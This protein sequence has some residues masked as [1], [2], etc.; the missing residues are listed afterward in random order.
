MFI[1]YGASKFFYNNPLDLFNIDNFTFQLSVYNQVSK[2]LFKHQDEENLI[3]VKDINE[4][5]E[6]YYI[7]E[8]FYIGF[9]DE[10]KVNM[11]ILRI[12]LKD[13]I[14][15]VKSL[16]I[17][18]ISLVLKLMVF[19]I[20]IRR[21]VFSFVFDFISS[22]IVDKNLLSMVFIQSRIYSYLGF[23]SMGDSY[24]ISLG[25][26]QDCSQHN[27][28]KEFNGFY[29]LYF[30]NDNLLTYGFYLVLSKK[31]QHF[32]LYGFYDQLAIIFFRFS[33]N[34]SGQYAR[35][36]F[37]FNFLDLFLKTDDFKITLFVLLTTKKK[38]KI[39]IVILLFY[40][41]INIGVIKRGGRFIPFFSVGIS[42]SIDFVEITSVFEESKNKLITL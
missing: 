27:F 34:D 23:F 28:N 15:K 31:F 11:L 42:G 6:T 2:Y 37:F 26:I 18:L 4:Y 19:V 13:L 33:Q 41:S 3:K 17:G 1:V 39:A 36:C 40:I 21:N 8:S 7:S 24:S 20:V 14:E 22:N 25:A 5:S 10:E 12:G 35:V 32:S 30:N 9:Q 16:K 29:I 38:F